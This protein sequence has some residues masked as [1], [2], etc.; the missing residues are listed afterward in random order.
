MNEILRCVPA[1]NI[2]NL[3]HMK[4]RISRGRYSVVFPVGRKMRDP[5]DHG[6]IFKISEIVVEKRSNT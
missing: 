6:K 4:A 3:E 2:V 1:S 5:E